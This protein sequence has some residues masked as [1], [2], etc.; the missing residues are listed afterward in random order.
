MTMTP[1]LK[2][3]LLVAIQNAIECH[4]TMRLEMIQRYNKECQEVIVEEQNLA[5]ARSLIKQLEAL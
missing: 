5:L 1:E 3:D 2:S 4:D